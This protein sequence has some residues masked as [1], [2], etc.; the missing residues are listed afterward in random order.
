MYVLEDIAA[1]QTG[2]LAL[3]GIQGKCQGL[4][5]LAG[6]PAR[7]TEA[8]DLLQV[9][10]QHH[11]A[12]L[13]AANTEAMSAERP[14]TTLSHSM[15]SRTTAI[16]PVPTE[17]Q[18]T[19]GSKSIPDPAHMTSPG[20]TGMTGT[21]MMTEAT[22]A[23]VLM[24][25]TLAAEEDEAAA[26]AQVA[27]LLRTAENGKGTA[28]ATMT[29]A[30]TG[31]HSNH[32]APTAT[33]TPAETT[34]IKTATM[35]TTDIGTRDPTVTEAE[36]GTAEQGPLPCIAQLC[37]DMYSQDVHPLHHSSVLPLASQSLLQCQQS[38][39][40]CTHRDT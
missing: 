24:I 16:V 12:R 7:Q 25:G 31:K 30:A 21:G 4:S 38:H 13:Q 27:G 9:L 22:T 3:A 28:L 20:S 14:L 40:T 10:I 11:S 23:A 8:A 33:G 37:M 34:D 15:P 29:A 6:L 36:T 35:A 18:S 26:A 5:L 39:H 17:M 1:V 19:A 2:C 32:E